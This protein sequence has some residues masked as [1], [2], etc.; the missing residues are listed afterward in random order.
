[1]YLT[2]WAIH[3][4]ILALIAQSVNLYIANKAILFNMFDRL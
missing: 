2:F 1:M 4:M 3:G